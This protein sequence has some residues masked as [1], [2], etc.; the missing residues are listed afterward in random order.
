VLQEAL[1]RGELAAWIDADA[2]ASAFVTLIDGF[3]V[4]VLEAG[5]LSVE[6]ARREAY[7]LLE[8]LVGAPATIPAAVEGL[9]ARAGDRPA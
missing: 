7:S 4:R 3:A 9:R 5:A 8:L 2:I 6:D 1:V